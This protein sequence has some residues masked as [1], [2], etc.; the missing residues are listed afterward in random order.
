MPPPP[1]SAQ[2]DGHPA[3]KASPI[4]GFA[5]HTAPNHGS[6]TAAASQG[7]HWPNNTFCSAGPLT[8]IQRR[9]G[10]PASRLQARS[11]IPKAVK[12]ATASR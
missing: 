2:R 10:G 9:Q 4:V 11:A 5:A 12:S 8:T 3:N 1:K 7:D 6:P